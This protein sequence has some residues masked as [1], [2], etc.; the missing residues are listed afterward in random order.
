MK[1]IT[2]QKELIMDY[3]IDCDMC[4][5]EVEVY[6]TRNTYDGRSVCTHCLGKHFSYVLTPDGEE[7]VLNE[8]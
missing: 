7:F 1:I 2:N 8:Q 6:D 4:G 5:S 3:Y